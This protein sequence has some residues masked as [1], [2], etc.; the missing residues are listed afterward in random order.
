M[1]EKYTY[2]PKYNDML[3]SDISDE[4]LDKAFAAMLS[5]VKS[6]PENVNP[7]KTIHQPA[8]IDKVTAVTDS[9][10]AMNRSFT[11]WSQILAEECG[12]YNTKYGYLVKNYD[13]VAYKY[14][15]DNDDEARKVV[16]HNLTAILRYKYF[17]VL[18]DSSHQ[19]IKEIVQWFCSSVY[20][21]VC[22]MT[23]NCN[24]DIRGSL[25]RDT[26]P[27][28]AV[29]FANGIYDFK[30][31]KWLLKYTRIKIPTI[32]N[33]MILYP[34]Y[35]VMWY[36]NYDFEPYDFGIE[37][38][39]FE[40]FISKM[41]NTPPDNSNLTWQ[42]FSNMAHDMSHKLTARRLQHFSEILGYT[43]MTPFVQSFVIL[44]GQGHNGKNSIF[45]GAFSNFVVPVP[46]QETLDKIEE[47]R[48]I[49]GTLN[50][51]SHNISLETKP[52][53]YKTSDQLKKL[54]GSDEFM[55]E[56]KGQTKRPVPMNCRFVFS[57]NDQNNVKFGDQTHGFERRCNLFEIY[58][59][60]DKNHE[61]LSW[62]PDYY[63]TD[64]Q[65][66]D[67]RQYTNNN[68]LF[69]YLGMYGIMSATKNFTH[70]FSFTYNEWSAAYADKDLE[71]E[72]FFKEEFIAEDLFR[73]WGDP[74]LN[75]NQA[76]YQDAFMIE[77]SARYSKAGAVK[78]HMASF[79]KDE[80]ECTS[81][82]DLSKKFKAYEQLTGYDSDG[83]EIYANEM[84]GVSFFRN[85]DMYVSL[86]YLRAIVKVARP[87]TIKDNG[88]TFNESFRKALNIKRSP[89]FAQN[90]SYVR[91]RMKGNRVEFLNE[92]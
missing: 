56:E 71:L 17:K 41:R 21:N 32:K 10:E 42:L 11:E 70:E 59:T 3:S 37:D 47:D 82:Q 15:G 54:T 80:F 65:L 60:W 58:Y 69:V 57:A 1:S 50:G 27:A 19:R 16:N 2:D 43:I 62:A 24:D 92:I 51:R 85:H 46:A 22:Y 67:I 84:V 7:V 90:K 74:C 36:F 49:G 20:N 66:N 64:F 61:Y 39:S 4:E 5:K 88:Y 30:E 77:D 31:N 73:R 75:V 33:A 48:F 14:I 89:R 81:W 29:A 72:S 53:V 25:R 76:V 40:E 78:L 9:Q 6:K 45:D 44:I 68:R 83:N 35:V 23:I 87:Y 12:V 34:K 63:K 28:S 38:V 86:D 79:V 91:I 13:D 52:G 55:I 8:I 26:L 18:D